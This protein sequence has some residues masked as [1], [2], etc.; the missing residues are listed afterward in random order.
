MESE[1]ETPRRRLGPDTPAKN[2]CHSASTPW[3]GP[4]N[5]LHAPLSTSAAPTRGVTSAM[6]TST[7][8]HV[9]PPR[10]RRQSISPDGTMFCLFQRSCRFTMWIRTRSTSTASVNTIRSGYRFVRATDTLMTRH[11]PLK[12]TA[13]QLRPLRARTNGPTHVGHH[14]DA[15][16]KTTNHVE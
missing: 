14:T 4:S 5:V 1:N 6:I 2:R 15:P 3:Y 12:M 7:V 8:V 16:R 9:S 13:S 10:R 11:A